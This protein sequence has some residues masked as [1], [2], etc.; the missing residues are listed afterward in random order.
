MRL[1]MTS[2]SDSTTWTFSC[3]LARQL[4][5]RHGVEV[6]LAIIGRSPSTSQLSLLPNH[7]P[8]VIELAQLPDT[9]PQGDH[10]RLWPAALE[11]LRHLMLQWHAHIIHANQ[12]ETAA[13][14]AVGLPV[15]VAAHKDLCSRRACLEGEN[16]PLVDDTYKR[17]VLDGLRAAASVTVPSPFLA[18]SLSQ[19]I[20]YDGV[21]RMIPYGLASSAS[22]RSSWDIDVIT[23]G[24]LWDPAAGL[25]CLVAAARQLSRRTFAA[26]GPLTPPEATRMRPQDNSLILTGEAT[27]EETGQLMA[28]ARIF[29]SAARYDPAA[30]GSIQAALAGC[31]LVLSDMPF[32]RLLWQDAAVYF[33]GRNPAALCREIQRLCS[34]DEACTRLREAASLR[35]RTA[36][37]PER[38]ADAYLATY[39]RLVLRYGI[40]A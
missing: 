38:M 9:A 18:H 1:L 5:E 14:G 31:C 3:T 23:S 35:A 37:S 19:W 17:M 2:S 24:D 20:G 4:A 30:L 13:V 11:E 36:H 26:I 6:L 8:S 15:V 34:D 28:Q 33:D 12:F 25:D 40:S 21:V 10:S 39:E 27:E 7:S 32:H 16:P 22:V 29:V